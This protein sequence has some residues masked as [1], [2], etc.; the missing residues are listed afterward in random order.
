MK[1]HSLRCEHIG[2]TRPSSAREKQHSWSWTFCVFSQGTVERSVQL[3]PRPLPHRG[4]HGPQQDGRREGAGVRPGEAAL[5]RRVH[6]T[7]RGLPV[8]GHPA[9]EVKVQRD[10]RRNAGHDA[11]VRAD[12]EAQALSAAGHAA[13]R[14]RAPELRVVIRAE[15]C[16]SLSWNPQRR[17]LEW[18][19]GHGLA[20]PNIW[21][22]FVS[23]LMHLVQLFQ[24]LHHLYHVHTSLF[25]RPYGFMLMLITY[26][27]FQ[28]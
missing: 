23:V 5:H 17:R 20:M 28:I 8:P 22:M 7:S 16:R 10:T 13:T 26:L 19:A 25:S 12:H 11:G 18:K 24:S 15:G 2:Q 6:R 3:Q 1:K 4:R 21:K 27:C 14:L 9:P